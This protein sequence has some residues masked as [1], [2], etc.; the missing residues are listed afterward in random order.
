MV[1]WEQFIT[2][3]EAK[4]GVDNH[5]SFMSAIIALK[6]KATVAEYCGEFQELMFKLCSH[7]PYYDETMFV[8]NFL[9]GL[10]QD[11]RIVVAAQLPETVDRAILLAHVQADLASKSKTWAPKPSF[12]GQART[13]THKPASRTV[14]GDFWKERQLKEYQRS[15]GLCFSCG[16]KYDP[17]HICAPKS[18]ATVHALSVKDHAMELSSE[19]LNLLEL[20]YI[21]EAQ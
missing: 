14:Q 16:D 5:R 12:G 9:R 17:T 18:Q 11:I 7:N 15:N 20:Q 21:A 10:K 3:V 19:V 6:Q 4:F 8:R 1:T 13:D 2:V